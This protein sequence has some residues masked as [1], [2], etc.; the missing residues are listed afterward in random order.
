M[1][2]TVRVAAIQTANRTIS[3][4]AGDDAAALE[5]VRDDLDS[6]IGLAERATDEGGAIIAFPEDTLGTLEWVTGHWDGVA[7]LP[8]A[9]GEES[10]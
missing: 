9:S 8:P 10:T 7:D 2:E 1:A 6:L 5:Q 3:Y 4:R